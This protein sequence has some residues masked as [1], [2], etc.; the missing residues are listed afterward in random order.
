MKNVSLLA[1]F[2]LCGAL[3][4]FARDTLPTPEILGKESIFTAQRLGA[5]DTIVVRAFSTD[6]AELANLDDEEKKIVEEIKP[7]IVKNLKES[8]VKNLKKE[9][10]FRNVLAKG[11][12]KGKAVI[13]EGKFTR[14]NGGIGAAKFFPGWMAPKSGKTNIS[15]TGRL[16]DAKTGKEL[17]TFSDTR[18]GGEG[19]GLGRIRG[20]MPVQA[21]DE[22]E[23]I[24]NFIRK[25]Y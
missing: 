15:V 22:G 12:P 17:A 7:T 6:G 10:K 13:V 14:F 25:L 11:E 5:Y 24:A 19:G 18:S 21:T 8:L 4:V 20:V 16:V 23:E 2:L 9:G 3:T 1:F